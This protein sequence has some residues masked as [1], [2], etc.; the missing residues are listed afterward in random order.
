MGRMFSGSDGFLKQQ[1]TAASGHLVC[2]R[3]FLLYLNPTRL[4]FCFLQVKKLRLTQVVS[5][6]WAHAAKRDRSGVYVLGLSGP[7]S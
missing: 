7:V 1:S 4:C 3:P 5:C 6:T 2:N